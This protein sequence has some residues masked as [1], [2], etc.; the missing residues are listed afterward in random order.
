[1]LLNVRVVHCFVMHPRHFQLWGAGSGGGGGGC[2]GEGY[3]IT[4]VRTSVR[5]KMV[6]ISFENVK[7]LVNWI[8]IL[9]T[10]I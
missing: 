4:A 9:Y 6:S 3:S 10:G 1:M 8:H 2:G 7:I 5:A